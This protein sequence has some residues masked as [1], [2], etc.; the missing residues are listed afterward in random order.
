MSPYLIKKGAGNKSIGGG[1]RGSF[2]IGQRA[3]WKWNAHENKVLR[4]KKNTSS[5]YLFSEFKILLRS[6][7]ST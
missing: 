7:I 1:R 6:I 4:V 3:M 2:D 5:F